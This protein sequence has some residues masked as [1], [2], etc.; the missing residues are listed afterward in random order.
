MA[1]D[2]L[3]RLQDWYVAQCDGAWEHQY[4]VTIE[5]LDNPGWR[6]TIDLTGTPLER[7][8]FDG[9]EI[10]RSEHDWL[11]CHVQDRKFVSG[12]GPRNLPD[13]LATFLDW[14]EA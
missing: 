10:K 7:R 3:T 1:E 12:C 9:V 4:G 8:D 6:V 5:S 14:A 11:D 13:L 2:L